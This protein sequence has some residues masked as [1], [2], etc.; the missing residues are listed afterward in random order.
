VLFMLW[1]LMKCFAVRQKND[2][3]KQKKR[4]EGKTRRFVANYDIKA[5]TMTNPCFY[6][7]YN[8]VFFY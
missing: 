8:S 7:N 5:K 6:K 2:A 3:N 1:L 4:R